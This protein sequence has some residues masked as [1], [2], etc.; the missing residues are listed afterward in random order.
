MIEAVSFLLYA[1]ATISASPSADTRDWGA[2]LRIDAK[3]LHDDIAANHPGP[4]NP[5]DPG[6]E[7]RN[8]TEFAIALRRAKGARTF[9]D[10][11]FAMQEYTSSFNDGHLGYGVWG[12]TPDEVRAWPGFLTRYDGN[13]NQI[14]FAS[15]SW[16]GVPLA[17]RLISCD[18]LSA[19][20]I[21]QKRVGSRVGRWNLGSQRVIFGALTFLDTGDPYVGTVRRCRFKSVG[22]T[23][24]VA[25]GWRAP[26]GDLYQRYQLFPR[27]GR[28]TVQWRSL[29]DGTEWFDIPS[30]DGNPDGEAGKS[31]RALLD[32]L[33][34]KGDDVRSAPAVVLDLRGNGG[35]SSDWSSRIAR[36]LWGQGAMDRH[37]EPS[38]TI[39]WRASAGN[40]DEVRKHYSEQ[41]K[42]G[43]LSPE[44]D[45]WYKETIA[46]LQKAIAERRQLWVIKPER[47]PRKDEAVAKEAHR[48]AGPVYVLT[49]SFC[50]S[51]CLDAVDLWTRLGAIP[52]GRE[53]GAD[54]LYMEVRQIALPAG[55]GA[56]SMPMKV[57]SGR[58]RKSN[59][60]VLP[61]HRF[62][63]DIADTA[64]L[65][66]WV[67]SLP[68]RRKP[69]G[70]N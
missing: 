63:G 49:D 51:A 38:M 59:Q 32:Y 41:S 7:A 28:R 54:T 2:A 16:S 10:Y 46:G 68:E 35:G 31:L 6:F 21:A 42:G 19:D 26:E 67:A 27:P 20:Q 29:S 18:G 13:G 60:P 40:L 65:E 25:L 37:P 62:R 53:T 4:V 56:V 9:A 47:A 34:S 8:D 50:M 39:S 1:L 69:D 55:L 22:R 64:A 70:S 44:M 12:A 15:E 43:H 23:I 57:Y 48:L 17:A 3:A 66:R 45:S 52:I 5:A 33:D 30:F 24:D 36:R 61:R 14:V 11:F 58:T